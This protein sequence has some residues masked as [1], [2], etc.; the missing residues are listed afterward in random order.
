[1]LEPL[2]PT[3]AVRGWAPAGAGL[4]WGVPRRPPAK[5]H[6]LPHTGLAGVGCGVCPTPG[7]GAAYAQLGG[8]KRRQRIAHPQATDCLTARSADHVEM[9]AAPDLVCRSGSAKMA[10]RF[11]A[12]R[13]ADRRG[14][15]HCREKRRR[16]IRRRAVRHRPGLRRRRSIHYPRHSVRSYRASHSSFCHRIDRHH[17]PPASDDPKFSNS[18]RRKSESAGSDWSIPKM[19]GNG[20]G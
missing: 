4:R 19:R 20:H 17:V 12:V 1:M 11:R 5:S 16:Q 15:R 9:A 8:L 7:T 10:G 2:V 14:L 13:N 6:R 3:A 18:D